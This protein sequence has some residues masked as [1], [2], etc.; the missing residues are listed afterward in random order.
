L[1]ADDHK[2]ELKALGL[3]PR[4]ADCDPLTGSKNDEVCFKESILESSNGDVGLGECSAVDCDRDSDCADGLLCAHQHKAELKDKGFDSRKAACDPLLGPK[5]GELCFKADLLERE[6]C[7]RTSCRSNP[8][9]V[10]NA[11]TVSNTEPISLAECLAFCETA[12]YIKFPSEPGP[13]ITGSVEVDNVYINLFYTPS[14]AGRP[15]TWLCSC[16]ESCDDFVSVPDDATFA[17]YDLLTAKNVECDDLM[18]VDL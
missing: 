2:A 14:G 6:V 5:S 16:V 11:R 18:I 17:S 12:E 1:C 8:T 7:P 4:K 9:E 3:D 15:D 13:P 10:F